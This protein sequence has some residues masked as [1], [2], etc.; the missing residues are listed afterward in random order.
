MKIITQ[1]T[2]LEITAGLASQFP[3]NQLPQAAFS[4]RSNVGKSSLINALIGRKN[5]ARVSS[6]PGKTITVNF[7]NVDKKM[8]IVDLP[9]YGYAKRTPADKERWSK[10]TD[11]Y[12]TSD[13][14]KPQLVVQLIDLKTGPTTDDDMM[15]EW[16]YRTETPYIVVATKADKLNVTD[17]KAALQALI[18]YEMIVEGTPVLPFSALKGEGRD[19]IFTE[20]TRRLGLN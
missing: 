1:N 13:G 10:L 3:K 18:D 12:F 14:G 9:G 15:L 16:L 6:A 5:Y 11:S 19:A 7:Y 20:I 8:Y 4:G 17:R 2:N